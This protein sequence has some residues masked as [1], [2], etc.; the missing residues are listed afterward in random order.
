MNLRNVSGSKNI[1]VVPRNDAT[2]NSPYTVTFTL[3]YSS[4]IRS[5]IEHLESF[6]DVRRKRD[7]LFI[8]GTSERDGSLTGNR[9]LGRFDG[10]RR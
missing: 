2:P 3:L 1:V 9:K 5:G 4:G 8:S 7:H 6:P 10:K